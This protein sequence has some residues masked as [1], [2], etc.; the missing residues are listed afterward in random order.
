MST[1]PRKLVE[2]LADT[3]PDV[4][5]GTCFNLEKTLTDTLRLT[6]QVLYEAGERVD[7]L[8]DKLNGPQPYDEEKD[9][10]PDCSGLL[11]QAERNLVLAETMALALTKLLAKL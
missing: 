11:A 3:I 5:P 4:E 8:R 10:M 6:E 9:R 7:A 2:V 1:E